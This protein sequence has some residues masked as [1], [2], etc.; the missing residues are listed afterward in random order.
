MASFDLAALALE[1]YDTLDVG[2]KRL[3]ALKRLYWELC[4]KL[5]DDGLKRAAYRGG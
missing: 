2:A 1:H 3:L 4:V 5:G